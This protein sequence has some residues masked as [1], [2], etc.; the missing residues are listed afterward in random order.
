MC[1]CRHCC[2]QELRQAQEAL[3]REQQRS[4]QQALEVGQL[5]KALAEATAKAAHQARQHATAAQE[6]EEVSLPGSPD[7]DLCLCLRLI[8]GQCI[9]QQDSTWLLPERLCRPV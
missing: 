8:P 7:S 2:L 3:K 1:T 6:L 5:T 9:R 4:Q